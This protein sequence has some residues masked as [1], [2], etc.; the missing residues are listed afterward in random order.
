MLG[1]LK[2]TKRSVTSCIATDAEAACT[3]T[4]FIGDIEL[5]AERAGTDRIRFF[6][7]AKSEQLISSCYRW[8]MEGSASL[9]QE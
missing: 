2:G 5:H 7:H 1:K 8:G 4:T 6:G 3:T 9:C